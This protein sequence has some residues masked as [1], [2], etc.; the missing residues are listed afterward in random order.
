MSVQPKPLESGEQKTA[1]QSE[2]TVAG[3]KPRR[4]N[5]LIGTS[6]STA[7]GQT[8]RKRISLFVTRLKPE[9]TPTDIQN[10]VKEQFNVDASCEK[11]ETK[12]DSYSSFKISCVCDSIDKFYDSENWP[13]NILVRRFY[14][15]RK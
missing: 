14:E 7:L 15:P 3:R 8:S 4:K 2:W 1:K 6:S 13:Q 12:F 5:F 9:T 10:Y 11:L